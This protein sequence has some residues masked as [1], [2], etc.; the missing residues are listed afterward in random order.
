MDAEGLRLAMRG[1]S[2]RPR[3][4]VSASDM[5]EDEDRDDI[6]IRP[7]SWGCG[8]VGTG[9]ASCMSMSEAIEVVARNRHSRT[10]WIWRGPAWRLDL[11]N[12]GGWVWSLG[13]ESER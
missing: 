13:G 1:R 4:S 8:R 6:C 2:E 10:G 3:R 7:P 12:L 11:A 9:E 5:D